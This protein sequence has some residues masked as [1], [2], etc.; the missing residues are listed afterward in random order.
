VRSGCEVL[1]GQ[2]HLGCNAA[3]SSLHRLC[4]SWGQLQLHRQG[5]PCED[6]ASSVTGWHHKGWKRL[7][8]LCGMK[9][10]GIGSPELL[11]LAAEAMQELA[12]RAAAPA[13]AAAAPA[14]AVA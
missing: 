11:Q 12:S 13:G 6:G 8:P 4:R 3:G 2:A 14:G 7:Q 5:Q 1:L 10:L 9:I